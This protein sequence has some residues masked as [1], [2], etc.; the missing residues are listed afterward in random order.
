MEN[1]KVRNILQVLHALI[2]ARVSVDTLLNQIRQLQLQL[3]VHV[4]CAMQ[5]HINHLGHTMA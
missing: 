4:K 1:T 3:I 5:V 2:G